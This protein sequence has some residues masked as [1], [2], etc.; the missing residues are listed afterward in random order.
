MKTKLQKGLSVL[1][2]MLMFTAV[3]GV[4]AQADESVNR[5]LFINVN[6]FDG[7]SGTLKANTNVL[8]EGNM[9]ASVGGRESADIDITVVDGGGRTLMPGLIDSHM[10]F[11]GYTPFNI[12]ARQS[13]NEFMVGGLAMVRGESMI[14]RGFTTVRDL[15]GALDV[16]EEAV[17]PSTGARS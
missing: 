15:G 14:M 3:S 5:T 16:F 9:I 8:V 6:V 17:G 13:V 12:N 7:R 1:V 11:A 10:H 4:N 2:S